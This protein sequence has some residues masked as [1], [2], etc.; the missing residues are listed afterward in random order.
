MQDDL[1]RAYDW[2]LKNNMEFNANKFELMRY[3]KHNETY[4]YDTLLLRTK[5]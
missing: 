2:A 3:N 1:N 4:K 5:Q